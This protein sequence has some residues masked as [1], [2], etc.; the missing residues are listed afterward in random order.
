MSRGAEPAAGPQADPLRDPFLV[1]QWQAVNLLN[2]TEVLLA[3]RN[4]VG[5]R[6]RDRKPKLVIVTVSG[7]GIRASVWTSVVLR[8][9]E[10]T[11]G[12]DFPYHIRLVTGASGGMVAGSYY[13]ASLVPPPEHVLRGGRADFAELHGTSIEE[14]V[15]RMATD[16]L[17]AV[18]GRMLFADL[19]AALSPLARHRDRGRTLEST[20]IR[21]RPSSSSASSRTPTTSACRRRFA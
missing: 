20:W 4:L 5:N 9:L 14:F 7:G 16:Q 12:A 18:A 2:N 15:D 10:A 13:A 17:D 1:G 3:W 21:C 6:W 19:P 11:L 8:K